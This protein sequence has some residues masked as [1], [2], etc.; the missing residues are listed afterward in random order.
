MKRFFF[1]AGDPSGDERAAEVVRAL[2]ALAPDCQ[3]TA[4]GGPGLRACADRF[5]FDLVGEGVMGFWEPLKKLP[6]FWRI[7]NEVVRPALRDLGPGVVVPTDFYGFNRHVA[8]AA[9]DA[10]RRVIYFVSPQV[11]ASR[12]GRVKVLKEVVDRMLVIFPFEEALYRA[13]GVPVTFVGHPLVDAIPAA[14]SA[15]ATVEPRIGLLPGS[16]PAEVRRLLPVMLAAA[17]RL[18]RQRRGL[19]CVLFA[20]PNLPNAFYDQFLGGETRRPYLLELVRDEGHRWRRSLDAAL[21]CSGTATLENALLGIPTVVAYRTSWPTYVLA[22]LLVR[23][24]HIA[25]PNILAGRTLMPERIQ[26]AA[27]PKGL[28]D[29]LS[30]FLDDLALRR[31]RQ[32]ELAALRTLLGGGGAARRA[33]QALL[34]AA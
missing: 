29:A 17:E 31:R 32:D 5:L 21:A 15:P 10:G 14:V 13:S 20:A 18:A 25:M 27:T 24:D 30:P 6:R 12:P 34:E 26:G 16:R 22:R 11:W 4:L 8:R 1:V 2:R 9:K 3:V 7:L 33:A 28:A 23:V 19:R